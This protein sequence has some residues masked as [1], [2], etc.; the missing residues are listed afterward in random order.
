MWIEFSVGSTFQE[1]RHYGSGIVRIIEKE[2]RALKR[3]HGCVAKMSLVFTFL[4]LKLKK[5]RDDKTTIFTKLLQDARGKEY[6]KQVTRKGL[7]R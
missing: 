6:R 5:T 4:V 7:N 1:A 3:N 2:K